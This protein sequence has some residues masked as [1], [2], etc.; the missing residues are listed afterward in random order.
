MTII[1][2]Y[3][4]IVMILCPFLNWYN[5]KWFKYTLQISLWFISFSILFIIKEMG[6]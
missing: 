6:Y 4:F 1:K 5:E 3:M 2:I